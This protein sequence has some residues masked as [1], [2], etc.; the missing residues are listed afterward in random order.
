MMMLCNNLRT[1]A[2]LQVPKVLV[3]TM[4]AGR[5][6]LKIRFLL[7]K[8]FFLKHENNRVIGSR[9]RSLKITL[10]F[11]RPISFP[12]IDIEL[13]ADDVIIRDFF[14]KKNIYKNLRCSLNPLLNS[15]SDCLKL[16][17][18]QKWMTM[19]K[20]SQFV[21]TSHHIILP[22]HS[23]CALESETLK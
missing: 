7:S 9:F 17:R 6:T 23:T 10:I 22:Q 2:G 12:Q 4:R 11:S 19:T 16:L 14:S 15:F 1:I 13:I 3:H 5:L 18:M 8:K 20:L 21:R